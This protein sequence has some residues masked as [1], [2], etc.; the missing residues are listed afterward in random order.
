MTKKFDFMAILPVGKE[1]KISSEDLAKKLGVNK[2]ELQEHIAEARANGDLI[3]SSASGGYF[4]PA[5]RE[6]VVEFDKTLS[7]RALNTLKAR[8]VARQYLKN[9][10]PKPFEQVSFGEHD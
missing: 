8:K 5:C 6:E 1:N 7:C 9:T 4:L 3:L 2:R 10:Y